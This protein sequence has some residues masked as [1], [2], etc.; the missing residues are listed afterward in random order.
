MSSTITN[1][2]N[3]INVNYP[4]P[5]QDNDSQGFRTNFSKI[6]SALNFAG[7]EITALQVNSVKLNDTN[8]FGNNIIKKA[9]FINCS[10]VA[11]SGTPDEGIISVDLN[12]GGYQ[13]F[14][15]SESGTYNINILGPSYPPSGYCGKVRLEIERDAGGVTINFAGDNTLLTGRTEKSVVYSN[16]GTCVW[17]VWTPDA[18]VTLIA[19]EVVGAPSDVVTLR[20]FTPQQLANWTTTTS[21][22]VNTGTLVYITSSTF[23]ALAYY[24]GSGWYTFTG[25]LAVL[26]TGVVGGPTS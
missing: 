8:D 15:I 19:N 4:I 1:Y 25:V 7:G 13:R 26:P 20:R 14:T 18:G 22:A 23:N 9:A 6:Q 21:A 17:D 10:D 2:S 3:A 16:T 5:G 12:N 11:Y 24:N